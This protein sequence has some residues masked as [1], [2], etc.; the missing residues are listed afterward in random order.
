MKEYQDLPF[1]VP[2]PA[3]GQLLLGEPFP[4]TERSP[5]QSWQL[6]AVWALLALLSLLSAV[7]AGKVLLGSAV[8]YN[9]EMNAAFFALGLAVS[10][11]LSLFLMKSKKK[12]G[13]VMAAL[14]LAV[15]T[16]TYTCL[17]YYL[18]GKTGFGLLDPGAFFG[19]FSIELFY[20]LLCLGGLSLVCAKSVRAALKISLATLVVCVCTGLFFGFTLG[21]SILLG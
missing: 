2:T 5:A 3:S 9:F 12:I 21:L 6:P 13:W 17:N 10:S 20:Y 14:P 16:G 7:H 8:R 4:E 1:R 18:L 11:L 19:D 15:V